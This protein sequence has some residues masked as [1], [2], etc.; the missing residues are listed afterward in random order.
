MKKQSV[1]LKGNI[2]YSEDKQ[3]IATAEHGYLVCEDG[4]CRGVFADIPSEWHHL[5]VEDWGDCLI[6][7][8]LTDLHVHAPQYAFRGIGM[9][10][11]LLEWLDTYTFPEEAKYADPE[12]AQR[13]YEIFVRD[14]ARSATTRA[15]IFATIHVPATER[16]MQLL[17]QT[18]MV[19]YVGKVNMDRNSPDSL[20]EASAE[21][22]ERDTVRWLDACR[23]MQRTHPMLTPR[24][25][26]SCTDELMQRLGEL[27]K[28]CGLRVQSHLSENRDEIAWVRQLNPKASCYGDAYRMFGLFGGDVP[29][30]MAHCVSSEEE[31]I[32]MMRDNQVYIAHCPQSNENLTSG[33][34][35]VRRYL[36][37]DMRVGLGTDIAAGSSLSIFRAMADA[38]QMS[39][40][41]C[42]YVDETARP[43]NT[44]EAFYLGT[45]GG[46]SFFG[47]VGSFLPGYTFDAVVMD[48]SAI[49]SPMQ[50][51]VRQRLERM[52]YL[53]EQCTVR[54]KY[55]AGVE[56]RQV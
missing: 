1:I 25:V 27:Q 13:A 24:F 35:P 50:L 33:I 41:Y 3:H 5:P 9:D 47:K 34:A 46:G 6:V 29:T 10:R 7:P 31:E 14:L 16:L 44:A 11:Q 54:K 20:T 39:K 48:D 40:M 45:M 21:A 22:S 52:L 49:V 43:L 32:A 8:G 12:Y 36:D 38:V 23:E 30:V 42:R 26:P 28:R 37:M 56:V 18:G 2:C 19:T 17:E 4:I 53:S 51:N 15:C 55:V